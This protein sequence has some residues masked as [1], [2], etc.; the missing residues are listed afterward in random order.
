MRSDW[1]RSSKSRTTKEAK[2]CSPIHVIIADSELTT[3][4]GTSKKAIMIKYKSVYDPIRR[5]EDGLRILA[6]RFR[7]RGLPKKRCDIWMAN[8]APSESTLKLWRSYKIGW[9]EFTQK[10][11]RELLESG[12]S[13]A[14]NKRI[15]NYGQK[16][17]LRLVQ[18]LGKKQRITLMC[19]CDQREKHCHLKILGR[20]LN[21]KI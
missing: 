2:R 18:L 11:K 14:K 19:H 8:L 16:W 13:D 3:K 6:T 5:K 21:S 9:R 7:G 12:S 4:A 15:K 1:E 20:V 17:S 10:Y